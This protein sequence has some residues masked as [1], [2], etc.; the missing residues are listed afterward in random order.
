MIDEERF[1]AWLDGELGA[2]ESAAVAAA[3]ARDPELSAKAERHRAVA[4]RLRG[5]FEPLAGEPVALPGAAVIDLA[6][7]RRLRGER[8]WW[9]DA[10]ALAATLVLGVAIGTRLLGSDSSPVAVNGETLVAS[11]GLERSLDRHLASAPEGGG[12]RIGLTFRDRDGRICRTFDSPSSSG[13]ACREADDWAV[14]A[15]VGPAEGQS[16]EFRMAAGPDP[17]LA[18][19]VD[20]IIS[21]E[22]FDAAQEK[23]ARDRGWTSR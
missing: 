20:A 16:G 1:F 18:A 12:H 17:R 2:E 4:A 13:L 21:G 8:R 7:A 11:A 22:P 9:H 15:L 14:E 23:A 5:A 19:M 10:A 3:V 6:A